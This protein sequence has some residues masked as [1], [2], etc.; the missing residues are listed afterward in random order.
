MAG[1]DEA[2]TLRPG[3]HDPRPRRA[4]VLAL[5][6]GTVVGG[7]GGLIGLGGA[8]FRLPILI[9]LFGYALRRAVRLNLTI[10]LVT[11]VSAAAARLALGGHLPG[12]VLPVAAAMAA[13]GVAG[14]RAGASWL[15]RISDRRLERTVR[16]LL[17]GIGV[18]L[19][20]ESALPWEPAVS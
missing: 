7:L 20:V 6:A 15:A 13:G 3:V 18:L 2:D 4:A 5:V 10:S 16:A 14:A 9:G 1:K 12:A 8:E 17:L 19:I 11:V